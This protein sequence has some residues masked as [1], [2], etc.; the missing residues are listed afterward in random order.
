MNPRMRKHHDRTMHLHPLSTRNPKSI[1]FDLPPSACYITINNHKQHRFCCLA[2]RIFSFQT[3][4]K[5]VIHKTQSLVTIV[6]LWSVD[7]TRGFT[8]PLHHQWSSLQRS[9]FGS[10]STRFHRNPIISLSLSSSPGGKYDQGE[11]GE[12]KNWIEKSFPVGT[13]E[14]VSV[15]KVEDYNL[16]IS[17]EA[18]GTGPLSKRMFDTIISKTSLDMTEEIL[19]AFRLYALDFTAK[20]ASRAA[21]LQNGLE[22]VLLGEEEDQGMWG[23]V[24]AIRLYDTETGEPSPM[25]YD[26]LEEAVK[27]WEPGQSFDFVARQVPAKIRELSVDELVQALDPDGAIR[28]EAR[29][30]KEKQE[31]DMDDDEEEDE[32]FQ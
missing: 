3:K 20:E 8:Q 18:F 7:L 5:M 2:T 10:S 11:V 23:D 22:M 12:G 13:D 21:L 17:G 19:E 29:E 1:P 16:G 26:S 24:E 4:R 14:K 6:L 25:L 9:L 32:A 27:D 30:R 28:Q 15:K 31:D